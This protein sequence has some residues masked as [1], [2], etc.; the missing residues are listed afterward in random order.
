MTIFFYRSK[1]AFLHSVGQRPNVTHDTIIACKSWPDIILYEERSTYENTMIYTLFLGFFLN[2]WQLSFLDICLTRLKSQTH[3]KARLNMHWRAMMFSTSHSSQQIWPLLG[4]HSKYLW[5]L[6]LCGWYRPKWL[7][8]RSLQLWP[9][10][11]FCRLDW[12][13]PAIWLIIHGEWGGSRIIYFYLHL[14]EWQSLTDLTFF[15]I[16]LWPWIELASLDMFSPTFWPSVSK[17]LDQR[18][19]LAIQQER[20]SS[21][22]ACWS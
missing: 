7:V 13:E 9:V 8:K 20:W 19:W 21:G 15:S 2:S 6:R 11:W 18:P 5:R 1:G 12:W 3:G 14:Q 16:G 4:M 17:E 10:P 22:N